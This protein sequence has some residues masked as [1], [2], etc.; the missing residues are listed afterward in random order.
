MKYLSTLILLLILTSTTTQNPPIQLLQINAE[1]NTRNDVSLNLPKDYKG[2]RIHVDYALLEN[3]G[4]GFKKSVAGQ[5][6]PIIV[7]R[8]GGQTKY[9]WSADL[10][11]K[12]KLTKEEVIETLDKIL[13]LK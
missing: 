7:L 3:Q 9:Q 4:P 2:Y 5:P 11:F 1:W 13:K 8:V 6:L 12:L 10:S